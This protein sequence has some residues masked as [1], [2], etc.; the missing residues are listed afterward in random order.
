MEIRLATADDAGAIRKIYAPYVR[1]TA[2]SF[3]YEA[4]D[5]EE[6]ARRI[7]AT[8]SEYPWLAAT[9]HD[10]VVGYAYASVFHG[11]IAYKHSAEVSVYLDG[12]RRRA[13]IGSRLYRELETCLLRQNVFVLYACVTATD[14]AADAHWSDD[15][16]RFHEKQGYVPVGKHNLCGYKFDKWYSVVWME[17]VIA[18]RPEHPKPFV[19]FPA[20][21]AQKV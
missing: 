10:E 12:K 18:P 15:S 6:M 13:G 11:R 7:R 20:I 14:R 16:L 17:K 4:P 8:L 9:E 1:N 3:E 5:T 21:P 19:P 2:V